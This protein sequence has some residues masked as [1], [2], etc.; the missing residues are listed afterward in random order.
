[1]RPK[2]PTIIDGTWLNVPPIPTEAWHRR[3]VIL[4]FWATSCEASVH[5][6]RQLEIERDRLA[7]ASSHGNVAIIAVHTPRFEHEQH[8]DHVRAELAR[9]GVRLPVVHD[10][11]MATWAYYQPEGW[12]TVIAIDPHRR[13]IGALTGH[14]SVPLTD[15][16]DHVAASAQPSRRRA[17]DARP[18]LPTPAKTP[19]PPP[20]RS[21]WFPTGVARRGQQLLVVDR[22]RVRAHQLSTDLRSSV[23]VTASLEIQGAARVAWID[24]HRFVVSQPD[25]GQLQFHST[26]HPEG[27]RVISAGLERP[28][29]LAMDANRSLVI[30]DA[31]ADQLLCVADDE[32]AEEGYRVGPIAGSGFS[33]R[34]DGRSGRAELCE[35]TSVVRSDRGVFFTEAGSS[36]LRLA[37]DRGRVMTVVAGGHERDGIPEP[38]LIDGRAHRARLQRPSASAVRPDGSVAIADAGNHRLRLLSGRR[39]RTLPVSGLR[40]PLDVCCDSDRDGL[41]FVADTHR[42][43]VVVVDPEMERTWTLSLLD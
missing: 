13:V 2:A 29:G 20:D 18:P 36:T 40:Y 25:E 38:G 27:G 26:Q 35:P 21:L 6:L 16:I 4:L 1:M 34:M 8:A 10:A 41:L 19:G 14:A 31:V 28:V 42:H 23:A 9:L 11:T 24:E 33:G 17:S 7:A 32:H 5:R 43:R 3:G 37:S 30:A 15:L 12:P 22:N 39:V